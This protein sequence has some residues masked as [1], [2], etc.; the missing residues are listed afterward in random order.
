MAHVYEYDVFISYHRDND[1]VAR[2]VRNHFR[3]LLSD[4]LNDN[5]SEKVRVFTDDDVAI[6]GEWPAV[7]KDAL[8]AAKV[9]VVVCSPQYFR[10]EWCLAEW[11][12]MARREQQE[13]V[14]AHGLICPV[15][16]SDSYSYPDWAKR[17]HMRDFSDWSEPSPHF[18]DSQDFL[19]FSRE[20]RY[21]AEEL[22]PRILRA[23]RWQSGWPVVMPD[24][25]PPPTFAK[26]RL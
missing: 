5:M 17:R 21:L 26:P 7:L 25:E 19:T 10:N 12:S 3:K 4:R 6:G 14:G 18:Q 20:V 15:I 13:S 11:E 2:W 22:T 8:L 24:P 9:L 1:T 16:Y 23:P